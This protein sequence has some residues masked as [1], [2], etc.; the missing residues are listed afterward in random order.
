MLHKFLLLYA[1]L[2]RSFLFFLPDVPFIMRIRGFLYGLG[3][4][5][6][7]RNFQVAHSA[8]INGLDR[9]CIGKNVY[10]AN[11]CNLILN[12]TLEIG[13]EVI[14][15]PAVLVSTGNHQFDGDSYR[16]S[17]S[18][19]DPVIIG[20]G[21]WIGGNSTILGGTLVPEKSIIGAGSVVTKKS[22]SSVSGI[23]AGCPAKLIKE[24]CYQ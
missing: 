23:Y 9:C 5:R 2:V 22:C 1:W 16:F 24:I 3:M 10:I 4:R 15:G 14:L 11:S 17:S 12:G 7:G 20:K 21:C 13:N 8:I 19:Q 6:C 18:L